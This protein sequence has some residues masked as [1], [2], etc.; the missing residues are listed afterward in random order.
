M[1]FRCELTIH[2]TIHLHW[3]DDATEKPSKRI[4]CLGTLK[5]RANRLLPT[6]N[7]LQLF[8]VFPPYGESGTH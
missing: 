5:V 4:K 8:S 7:S 1:L 6:A 2:H 3:F